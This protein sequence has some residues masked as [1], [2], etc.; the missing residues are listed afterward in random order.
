MRRTLPMVIT[1]VT[2]LIVILKDIFISPTFNTL[3]QT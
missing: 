1:L 3:V 2:G